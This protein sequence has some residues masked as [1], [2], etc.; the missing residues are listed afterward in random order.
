[1]TGRL[2]VVRDSD[3]GDRFRI[4]AEDGQ[5]MTTSEPYTSKSS[6]LKR[7]AGNQEQRRPHPDRRPVKRRPAPHDHIPPRHPR[8][9]AQPDSW[10]RQAQAV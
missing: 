8:R 7:G 4:E 3:D 6:A 5:L 10:Q 1:M 2:V 9:L